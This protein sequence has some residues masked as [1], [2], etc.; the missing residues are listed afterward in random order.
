MENRSH[1]ADPAASGRLRGYQVIISQMF[2]KILSYN[3]AVERNLIIVFIHCSE[4]HIHTQNIKR[5]YGAFQQNIKYIFYMVDID[6][7]E[8]IS[9]GFDFSQQ[10]HTCTSPL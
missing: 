9:Q 10:I 7:R 5:S 4:S 6:S 3:T 2:Q 8:Q 1:L